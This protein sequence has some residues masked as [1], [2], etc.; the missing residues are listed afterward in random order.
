M[1]ALSALL[2]DV[3]TINPFSTLRA[4]RALKRARDQRNRLSADMAEI[5]AFYDRMIHDQPIDNIGNALKAS[6]FVAGCA[7]RVS[8]I[9]TMWIQ[10]CNEIDQ[11][12]ALTITILGVYLA[13]VSLLISVASILFTLR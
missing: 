8:T 10:L 2:I 9:R 13:C 5:V 4:M 6:W 3:T 7:H 1:A 12:M 11:K